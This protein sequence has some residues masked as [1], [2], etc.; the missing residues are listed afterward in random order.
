MSL[1][2]HFF[3]NDVDFWKMRKDIDTLQER[4][5][6]IQDEIEQ[7]DDDYEDAKSSAFNITH[8]LNEM[9]RAVGLYDVLWNPEDNGWGNYENLVSFCKLV[10]QKC[11]E[12]PDTVIEDAE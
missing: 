11:C 9:A 2:I 10:L 12:Y 4:L 5:R 6:A 8:N 7:L 3:K 1:D